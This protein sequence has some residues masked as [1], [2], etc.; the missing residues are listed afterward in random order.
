MLSEEE[1]GVLM[2]KANMLKY[3][4][5]KEG[6][7]QREVAELLNI[8]KNYYSMIETG[9]RTPGLQLAKKIA[10]LFNSTIDEIFFNQSDNET[11]SNSRESA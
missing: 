4:R 5:V 7:S 11:L 10:D 8:H 2:K 3:I 9:T 1:G 6:L